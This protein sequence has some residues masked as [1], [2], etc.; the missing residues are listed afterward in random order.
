MVLSV[1]VLRPCG[2]PG[3]TLAGPAPVRGDATTPR[4]DTVFAR[5]DAIAEP[6]F[7]AAPPVERRLRR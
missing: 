7:T 4:G 6:V 3:D 1:I 2:T 5:G